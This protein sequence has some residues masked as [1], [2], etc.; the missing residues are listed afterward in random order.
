M[1]G[2]VQSEKLSREHEKAKEKMEREQLAAELEVQKLWFSAAAEGKYKKLESFLEKQSVSDPDLRDEKG[3]AAIHL[4]AAAGHKKCVRTLLRANVSVDSQDREGMTGLHLALAGRHEETAQYLID[5]GANQKLRN[6]VGQT[7]AEYAKEL[8]NDMPEA[9]ASAGKQEAASETLNPLE[10]VKKEF[11]AAVVGGDVAKVFKMIK[12]GMHPDVTDKDGNT[13]LVLATGSGHSSVANALIDSG[14]NL[15]AANSAGET[16]LA[17]AR[18]ADLTALMKGEYNGHLV[19]L[20]QLLESKGAG[21]DASV[22]TSIHTQQPAVKTPPRTADPLELDRPSTSGA[23]RPGT[24]KT[25]PSSAS[26]RPAT[27]KKF[28]TSDLL[29]SA[30]GLFSVFDRNKAQDE[31][32][33]LEEDVKGVEKVQAKLAKAEQKAA[34]ATEKAEKAH[35]ELMARAEVR[36]VGV[37]QESVCLDCAA[38]CRCFCV[39]AFGARRKGASDARRCGVVWSGFPAQGRAD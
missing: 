38:G 18:R 10:L 11:F 24:A 9:P 39:R 37:E 23:E 6:N 25:R 27:A 3:A 22:F 34:V 8:N 5:K 13:A 28:S 2:G 31:V 26:R 32:R 14:C 15:N 17:I 12:D 33:R 19:A 29:K 20:V 35:K 30:S 7:A 16:A 21:E 36:V 4:A 1:R